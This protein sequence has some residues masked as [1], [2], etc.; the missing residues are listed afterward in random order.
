MELVVN[1]QAATE[2]RNA[3]DIARGRLDD[4]GKKAVEVQSNVAM[5]TKISSDTQQELELKRRNLEA[6]G[7]VPVSKIEQFQGN[8]DHTHKEIQKLQEELEAVQAELASEKEKAHSLPEQL[9]QAKKELTE[10]S[11]RVQELESAQQKLE[12]LLDN[13]RERVD[14]LLMQKSMASDLQQHNIEIKV[15]IKYSLHDVISN[16][17][18]FILYI[19]IK[20][21]IQHQ[22]ATAKKE[23]EAKAAEVAK[24]KETV[25]YQEREVQRLSAELRSREALLQPL[26]MQLSQSQMTRP[27]HTQEMKSKEELQRLS[28]EVSELRSKLYR[29]EDAKQE[30]QRQME[31]AELKSR[32]LQEF[33]RESRQTPPPVPPRRARKSISTSQVSISLVIINVVKKNYF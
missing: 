32:L 30:A 27:D 9:Q 7:K 18:V 20:K 16:I 29:A 33:I 1:K 22:L 12:T 24:L 28:E 11:V 25:A 26:L 23:L 8:A 13:Q 15:L 31:T 10:K 21:I 2:A 3:R 19:L 6:L 14:L 4:V 5:L 17:I